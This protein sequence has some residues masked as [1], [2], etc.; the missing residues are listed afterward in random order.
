MDTP[1]AEGFS[2]SNDLLD[3]VFSDT[4][5]QD[6]STEDT[7]T[8]QESGEQEDD[9][10]ITAAEQSDESAPDEFD[11]D[12]LLSDEDEGDPEQVEEDGRTAFKMSQARMQ[13]FVAAKKLADGIAEFAPSVEAAKQHYQRASDFDAMEADFQNPHELVEVNGQEVPA[14]RAWLDHWAS[15]SPD[16]IGAVAE[17]LPQFLA[18]NRHPALQKI[19]Q[20]VVSAQINRLYRQAATSGD[21]EDLARAQN[22]DFAL[23]GKFKQQV[24]PVQQRNP[25]A[26]T[27]QQ[28]EQILQ[29][30]EAQTINREWKAFDSQNLTGAKEATLKSNLDK[31]FESPEV[32]QALKPTVLSALRDTVAN[33][34]QAKLTANT[35]WARNHSIRLRNIQ[36]EFTDAIRSNRE[37]NLGPTAKA[38][39]ADYDAQ[40]RRE[41]FAVAK[42]L[43]RDATQSV[44]NGNRALHQKLEASS[45]K[46]NPSSGAGGP[47]RRSIAPPVKQFSSR[48]E[49]LASID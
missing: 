22:A 44:V 38:L 9:P 3:S 25:Q 47:V 8:Q 48:E 26:D 29:Q 46:R 32:K 2:N 27:L 10:A 39:V 4:S 41:I 40:I 21:P 23:T 15:V 1:S 33:Q 11:L 31:I 12:K 24:D 7:G 14:A 16:G 37:T 30:R 19:E 5:S 42:P 36:R 6:T 28:R 43:L 13:R 34:I 17:M 18:E 35:E 49:A 20:T 45:G